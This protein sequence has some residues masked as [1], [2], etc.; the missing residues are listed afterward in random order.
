MM[1]AV[2]TSSATSFHACIQSYHGIRKDMSAD[3][4][5]I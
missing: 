2:G 1:H 4:L 5:W 3:S